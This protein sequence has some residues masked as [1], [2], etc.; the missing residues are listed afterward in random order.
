MNDLAKFRF[1]LLLRQ[2]L[3][4][5][6]MCGAAC[7]VPFAL[8]LAFSSYVRPDKI[9]WDMSTGFSFVVSMIL[10]TYLGSHLFKDEQTRK[11]LSFVLTLKASRK[12]WIYGNWC[13][14]AALLG[15]SIVGWTVLVTLGALLA[16]GIFPPPILYQAQLLLILESVLV[17]AI[18]M[19]FS[20]FMRPLLAWFLV[21][22]LCTL[23]H[24]KTYL[25]MLVVESHFE[26]LTKFVYN[27]I[28]FILNFLPPLEW[29][30]IRMFVGFY[31]P[32]SLF[33]ILLVV[34][35][36]MAWTYIILFISRL[37]LEGK[38]L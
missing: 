31:E 10:A 11:T 37:T 26:G 36:T 25:E 14:I 16:S 27:S 35:L 22:A 18:S 21:G 5:G 32:V 20:F 23:L 19:L 6:A 33:Q 29:W 8:F 28:L 4:W 38:D 1:K 15:V 2:K 12:D 24:S 7:Y 9:F 34:G 30:D 3:G 17:L 13:G